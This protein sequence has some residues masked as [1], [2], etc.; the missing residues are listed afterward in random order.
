MK[1]LQLF[2]SWHSFCTLAISSGGGGVG[3]L[4]L[5]STSQLTHLSVFSDITSLASLLGI[6]KKDFLR[7][8]FKESF[9]MWLSCGW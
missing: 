3:G 2:L 6:F 7:H 5:F 1:N 8:P 9:I 4:S